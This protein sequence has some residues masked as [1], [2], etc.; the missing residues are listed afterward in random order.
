MIGNRKQSG[1]L[2]VAAAAGAVSLLA[3]QLPRPRILTGIWRGIPVHYVIKHRLPIFEGDIILD[4]VLS[5]PVENRSHRTIGPRSFGIAYTS[6]LWPIAGMVHHVPY[7][8]SNNTANVTTAIGMFNN[9]LGGVI[10][11]VPRTTETD[12]VNINLDPNNFCSCGESNVGR[13][14]SEQTLNC[15]INCTPSGLLHEM[16]HTVGL[17]HEQSRPDRDN[18]I[19]LD[20]NHIRADSVGNDDKLMDNAQILGLF[21]YGSIMEYFAF[22]LTADGVQTRQ[23]IPA[24]IPLSNTTTYTAGDIDELRRL[25][26]ATPTRVTIATNPPGLQVVIDGSTFV[27]P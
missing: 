26:G 12:Y 19:T 15:A 20:Y 11:W 4:H 18:Y 24:G 5:H 25:Y 10:Q 1:V 2:V 6:Y 23:T 9:A 8:V 14:G 3:G 13:V 7:I 21:D 22:N 17:W 27:T 16:G